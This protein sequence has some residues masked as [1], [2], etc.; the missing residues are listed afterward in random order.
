MKASSSWTR[1]YSTALPTRAKYLSLTTRTTSPTTGATNEQQGSQ[2]EAEHGAPVRVP[3][4]SDLALARRG[5]PEGV[6][7]GA[8]DPAPALQAGHR[9]LQGV[10]ADPRPPEDDRQLRAGRRQHPAGGEDC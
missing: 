9:A 7:T 4:G 3:R 5:K 6:L 2:Q 1:T 10:Q 8:Q